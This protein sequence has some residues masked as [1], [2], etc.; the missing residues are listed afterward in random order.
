M[1]MRRGFFTLVVLVAVLGLAGFA[2]AAEMETAKI[3]M[4]APMS[5]PAAAWGLPGL[6]GLTIFVDKVNARGGLK[7]G[8]K[9]YKLEIVTYDDEG[10][11]A[12]ALLG[13]K[14]LVLEDKVKVVLMLGGGT[15]APTQPFL[16]KE[17]VLCLTLI[18]SDNAPDRPYHMVLTDNF[19][20]YHLL[21]PMYLAKSKPNF[22][23]AAVIAQDDPIGLPSIAWSEAGF[24][25]AG[26]EVVYSKSFAV[27]TTDFAPIVTAVL[28]SKPDIISMGAS[29]PEFQALIAEQGYTQGF[30][31]VYTSACWD[32]SAIAAKVPK[33]HMEG[34]VSSFPP[35]N[36]PSLSKE[37][38]DLWNE[39]K[40]RWPDHSW[41][42]ITW[43]Y[44]G[45]AE[46]WAWA[47]EKAGTFDTEA[48][49]KTLKSSETVPHSFGPGKWFGK[50][51]WGSDNLLAPKWPVTAMLNGQET[52]VD[53]FSAVEWI[54]DPA[55]KKILIDCLKA[56][57]VPVFGQ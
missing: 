4:C 15:T 10:D 19:P 51:V 2:P 25:G 35:F 48:V 28:A 50:E 34:S 11:G 45:N 29:Y 40:K 38:H 41:S 31:G 23:R 18:G 57:N 39:W 55:K 46:V 14:K 32:F 27:T 47:V 52:A 21:H 30:K 13:V 3:G 43:E 54:S 9:S 7:V 8:E 1:A 44:G 6:D 24:K 22:K 49:L 12:K 42:E 5:G 16:T 56:W 33:E 26:I 20:V 53:R 37:H 17:K 36:D